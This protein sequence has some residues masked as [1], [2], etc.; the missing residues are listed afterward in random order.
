MARKSKKRNN[1]K[2]KRNPTSLD[3]CRVPVSGF[4]NGS[5]TSGEFQMSLHPAELQ[6]GSTS[7]GLIASAFE[8]YRLT[9]VR[10]RLHPNGGTS[11]IGAVYVA[12]VVDNPPG[13]AVQV[14]A[15]PHHVFLSDDAVVPS[16]WRSVPPAAL[17]SYST[18][19]KTALGTPDPAQEVQGKV[20]FADTTGSTDQI[21]L[22]YVLA[23]EFR[24]LVST[25]M[26]PKERGAKECR[27]ERDRLLRLLASPTPAPA[28]ASRSLPPAALSK[29]GS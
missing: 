23:Y 1:N 13:T 14:C 18:W 28:Q 6:S 26:T 20:Y 17:R 24:S 29:G 19:C 12:G 7:A 16:P 4:L 10:Y 21:K 2:K 11:D 15:V 3:V 5:L 22:E 27:L 9:S 25:G 8:F